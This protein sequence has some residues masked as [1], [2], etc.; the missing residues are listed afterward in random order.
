MGESLRILLADYDAQ[1]SARVAA[2]LRSAGYDVTLRPDALTAHRD[3]RLDPPDLILVNAALPGG[4]GAT[5]VE[6]LGSNVHTAQV[7]IVAMV[8]DTNQGQTL[9]GAGARGCVT[10]P[11]DVEGLMGLVGQLLDRP[12][13]VLRA[14][15]TLVED[16][17]RLS[18]LDATR[19]LDSAPEPEF[20]LLTSLAARLL[21]APVALVSL[22]DRERQYFKSQV[23][24]GEP[25]AS[26]AETPL[27]HSFCQWAVVSQE[28]LVI[29]DARLHPLLRQNRAVAELGV[30]A[31]AGIPLVV[32][33]QTLGAMCA[34]DSR[35]RDWSD[36]EI[37]ILASLAKMCSAEMFFHLSHE[38]ADDSEAMRAASTG[39]A[40][41]VELLAAR[42]AAVNPDEVDVLVKILRAFSQRLEELAV[43]RRVATLTV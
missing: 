35:P 31:Y 42:A 17:M 7:P 10:K 40:G 27:T 6:R 8:N 2:G 5:L 11:V 23:G 30:T 28:P 9:L 32:L 14:P 3:A 15:R 1:E 20:D 22:V 34:I 18:V 29:S 26:A 39:L 19:L 36:E 16:P 43:A 12:V 38:D 33:D 25:W 13:P 41:V 4:G 21:P 24:L 37:A